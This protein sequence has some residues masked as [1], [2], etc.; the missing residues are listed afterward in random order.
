MSTPR[1]LARL[2]TPIHPL[3][4][5]SELLGCSVWIKRDDLTGAAL[6]GNKIR[7]LDCLLADAHT[8][9][10]T[11]IITCG[12]IQ[13]NHCRATAIAC[14]QHGLRPVLLLRGSPPPPRQLDGNLLLDALVGAEVR[15]TDADGYRSRDQHMA[16]IA[17]QLRSNGERPYIIPEGGSNAVGAMGFVHAGRELAAQAQAVGVQFDT[18]IVA[19]GSGGTLAGLAMS[20]LQANVLGVAVC[21][22]RATFRQRVHEIAQQAQTL[23]MGLTLPSDGWDVLEGHQGEGYAISTATELQQQAWLARSEG[24]IVDPVYTGKAWGALFSVLQQDPR[25]LGRRVLFWHTG[26]VFGVFGRGASY[27]QALDVPFVED[28]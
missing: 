23:N 20:G 5:A 15:W 17:E 3:Q 12:G 11:T 22:D 27:H 7:K 25:A 28:A 19:T 1:T 10:A 26:G 16:H 6:S 18:V 4:R 13:S 2:P 24:I 9:G 21:D 8:R 14:R